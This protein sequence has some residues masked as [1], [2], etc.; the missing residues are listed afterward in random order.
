MEPERAML[1]LRTER[2][3]LV[4]VTLELARAERTG[5]R[6]L[7]QALGAHVPPSWPPPLN[8][9]KTLRWTIDFLTAHAQGV[10]WGAWYF[11]H[12]E[13]GE[14]RLVGQGGFAGLPDDGTVEVGYSIV[15]ECHRFGFAPE[16]VNALVGW[17][18]THADVR[19][20]TA[21]TLPELRPS[22]RVLEKC[23]F[24]Q[25]GS[26]DEAGTVRYALERRDEPRPARR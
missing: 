22:I 2:L 18:F 15:P 21:Q 7:A 14:L 3:Q 8:D 19:R 25:V 16:A 20:V 13:H 26:G 12:R 4:A 17:A 23:G 5:P 24:V 10:G 6:R 11:L 1:H 9:E